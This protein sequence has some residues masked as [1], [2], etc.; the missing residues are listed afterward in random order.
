VPRV[1][2][3]VVVQGS[4][5]RVELPLVSLDTE[6]DITVFNAI[7]QRCI[8]LSGANAAN[9]GTIFLPSSSL[10]RG[11]YVVEI[12][13]KDGTVTRERVMIQ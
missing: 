8:V 9:D 4:D 13:L 10:S 2:P 5:I 3:N 12:R 6:T 1:L 11:L 7:G